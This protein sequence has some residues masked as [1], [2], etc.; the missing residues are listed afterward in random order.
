MQWCGNARAGWLRKG[1]KCCPEN[2]FQLS[3]AGGESDRLNFFFFSVG[4]PKKR[5]TEGGKCAAKG[6]VER[7]RKKT[8]TGAV[9]LVEREVCACVGEGGAASVKTE[10]GK[11][12]Q[13]GRWG[14]IQSSFS[15]FR[16]LPSLGAAAAVFTLVP[17]LEETV[18]GASGHCHT[19]FGDAQATY[20]VVVTSQDTCT[21]S[22]HRVPNI[23]VKVVI[24]GQ[25]QAA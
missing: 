5:A 2:G 4:R 7:E 6:W 1:S 11:K 25:E 16:R 10:P 9:H 14:V 8:K 3:S 23:A 15:S 17:Y 22:L 13:A 18:P 19:I 12:N 21:F 20:T 24:A